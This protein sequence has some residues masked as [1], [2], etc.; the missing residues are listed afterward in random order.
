MKLPD[1]WNNQC[2]PMVLRTPIVPRPQLQCSNPAT[3][4]GDQVELKTTML[5]K[6]DDVPQTMGQME[7]STTEAYAA[8]QYERK[9]SG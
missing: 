6:T 4:T 3:N 8:V 1:N 7:P 9:G 5:S 2:K